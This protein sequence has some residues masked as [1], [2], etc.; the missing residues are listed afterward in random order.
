METIYTIGHSALPWE[1][2]IAILQRHRIDVLVDIRRFPGSRREPQFNAVAM[3]LELE[4]AHIGYLHIAALGGR[5]KARPGSPSNAW[6]NA[7]F[8]GYADYME[9]E[10]FRVGLD[11]LM[12]L[13]RVQRVAIMC[14]EAVWWRCHRSMVADALTAN[15]WQVLH[16]MSD[17]SVRPHHLNEPA[18]LVDGQLTYHRPPSP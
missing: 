14:A 17:G 11:E 18:R 10:D 13:A 5:R 1:V 12:A 9:S 8:R 3:E 4:R 16:I 2:F 6:R 7:S 15:G